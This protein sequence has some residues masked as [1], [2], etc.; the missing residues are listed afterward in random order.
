[1]DSDHRN[2]VWAGRNF[3]EVIV[4]YIQKGRAAEAT[5]PFLLLNY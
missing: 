3:T 5:R 4:R 1:M 2:H